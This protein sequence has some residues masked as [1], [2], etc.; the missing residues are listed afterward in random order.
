MT[1]PVEGVEAPLCTYR[2]LGWLVA[3]NLHKDGTITYEDGT[4]TCG[5]CGGAIH[6]RPC[7]KSGNPHHPFQ[8][9]VSSTFDEDWGRIRGLLTSEDSAQRMRRTRE[10]VVNTAAIRAPLEAEVRE[11]RRERDLAIAHDGQPYPTADAYERTAEALYQQ[12]SRADHLEAEV[13]R[14]RGELGGLPAMVKQQADFILTA[15]NLDR[16]LS[17]TP[18][19]KGHH[20]Y[21]DGEYD[22][23]WYPVR[24]LQSRVIERIHHAISRALAPD[25]RG[26]A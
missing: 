10:A 21:G 25:E 22:A 17:E 11:L 5:H 12:R 13:A 14:L 9:P 8:P 6:G 18:W 24:D 2:R 16:P 3:C 4:I 26:K 1:N 23:R 19:L 20:R 15:A 7:T